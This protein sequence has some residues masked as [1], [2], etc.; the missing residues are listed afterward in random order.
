MFTLVYI[1]G[2]LNRPETLSTFLQTNIGKSPLLQVDCVTPYNGTEQDLV[3]AVCE[4]LNSVDS[5]IEV[6]YDGTQN[7]SK[8]EIK[9]NKQV[10]FI[11]MQVYVNSRI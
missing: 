4:H 11:V 1:N 10:H 9:N 2:K 8:E 7:I 5:Q 3:T 6:K